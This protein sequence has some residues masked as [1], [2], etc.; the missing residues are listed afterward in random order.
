MATTT[1]IFYKYIQILEKEKQKRT[2]DR[3]PTMSQCPQHPDLHPLPGICSSCLRE[4]LQDL[5]QNRYSSSLHLSNSGWSSPPPIHKTAGRGHRRNGSAVV[6]RSVSGGGSSTSHG[7]GL[8][9]SRSMAFVTRNRSTAGDQKRGFWSKL[10]HL[11]T[12]T[13]DHHHH[14]PLASTNSRNNT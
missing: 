2:I 9:K 8:R 10:I 5:S 6:L 4:R 11:K 13:R 14:H 12:T 1:C 3:S 7:G